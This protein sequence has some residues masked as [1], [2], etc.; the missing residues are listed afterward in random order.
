MAIVKILKSTSTF[1][2][3]SYNDKRCKNGEAI[4][5]TA[6][7][8]SLPDK[9]LPYSE[10]LISWSSKNKRIKN[11]QFHATISM[12]DNSLS[13]EQLLRISEEWLSKMGYG[14]NPYLIY[15][16]SNTKHPHVHIV[17]SRVDKNGNKI[18][19]SFEK[20]RALKCLHEIEGINQ[21]FDNRNALAHILHYSFSTKYQFI[22]LAKLSGFNVW[23][24]DK[25]IICKKGESKIHIN[26]ELIDFC[27][28]RYNREIDLKEK[29]KIQG[30]IYK[31][32]TILSK[33]SFTRFMK[34]NFGLNFIFYGKKNDIN[35]YTI[36]DYK[37]KCV[38]KGSEI[39]GTKKLTELLNIPESPV[40][41][42]EFKVH[43]YLKENPY[44]TSQELNESLFSH[45][46][47]ILDGDNLLNVFTGETYMLDSALINKLQYNHRLHYFV[48]CFNPYDND[49]YRIVAQLGRLKIED[50]QVLSSPLRPDHEMLLEYKTIFETALNDNLSLMHFLA[51]KGLSLYFNDNQFFIL[52][53]V[54]NRIV[55]NHLLNIDMSN[56]TSKID[57]DNDNTIDY[58]QDYYDAFDIYL[59]PSFDFAGLIFTGKVG[60]ARSGRRKKR[61]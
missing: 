4:L 42:Y 35:G 33:E 45:D 17:S 15:Y 55:S 37:N 47:Y 61:H 36:I 58:Q 5:L 14:N 24:D 44:A 10:Y 23:S 48:N 41:D 30:L 34:D 26:N 59:L 43:E 52:D 22:E 20:E 46:E 50:V 32:A 39:F 54:N 40:V 6:Q 29:K 12:K 27:V 11:T 9:L 25:Q 18:N 1:S 13:K 21:D 60:G 51:S 53:S 31:Y 38:Y 2:A 56:V 3:V 57:L 49:T 7:N 19:D 28:D 8:F 16:H